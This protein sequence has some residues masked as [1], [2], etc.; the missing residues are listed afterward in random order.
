MKRRPTEESL[1]HNREMLTN[2]LNEPKEKKCL[3]VLDDKELMPF[4][5]DLLVGWEFLYRPNTIDNG[6]VIEISY[7]EKMIP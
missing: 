5:I 7:H 3:L 6:A 2:I 1:K 4:V